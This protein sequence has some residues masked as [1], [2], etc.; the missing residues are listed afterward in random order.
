MEGINIKGSNYLTA[1]TCYRLL[2]P[3]LFPQYPRILY[4]DSDTL[5]LADPAELFESP[6]NGKIAGVMREAESKDLKEYYR[7]LGVEKAFNAGILLIDMALFREK[8]IG[9]QCLKLLVEDSK[10]PVR[11]L[12]Y[13][14]QDA[15][16]IVLRN[17]VCFLDSK[18][19]FCTVIWRT[20]I[21][22]V[23]DTERHIWQIPKL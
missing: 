16:N 12:Q 2:L 6:L 7:L 9:I 13:M 15:L 3:E 14:D 5:V 18:W 10:Q 11:R 8:K 20:W 23:Q 19:N 4:I 1:E 21:Y 22:Y 17:Q